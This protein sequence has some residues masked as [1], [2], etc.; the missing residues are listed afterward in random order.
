M[1]RAAGRVR[2]Q[3]CH[4]VLPP[5]PAGRACGDC[6]FLRQAVTGTLFRTTAWHATDLV[7]A[8]KP[9]RALLTA[10]SLQSRG[11]HHARMPHSVGTGT[12][13]SGSDSDASYFGSI[14]LDHNLVDALME[15][16]ISAP[17]PIQVFPAGAAAIA[18]FASASKLTPARGSG[19]SHP[20]DPAGQERGVWGT[21]RNRQDAV[22]PAPLGPTHEG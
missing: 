14:R 20:G 11:L 19:T 15:L 12:E 9:Q 4:T 18:G 21:H 16:G 22:V 17:S 3:L 7:V 2:Q 6:C 1:I 13:P 8:Q 10:T 5:A